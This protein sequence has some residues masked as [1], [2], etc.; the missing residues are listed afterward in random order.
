MSGLDLAKQ[1]QGL[2]PSLKVIISTG[3]SLELAR[4]NQLQAGGIA[5]LAKPYEGPTLAAAV[6]QCLEG[7]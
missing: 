3:Y 4:R 6:R 5:Y 2:K 1:L 7:A